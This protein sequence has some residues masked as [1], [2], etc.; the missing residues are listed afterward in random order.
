MILETLSCLSGVGDI[1]NSPFIVPVA[2]CF[3]IA[4][5]VIASTAAATR[6]REIESQERLAAIA[7]GIMPPPTHA[8]LELT[9]VQPATSAARRYYNIRLTGIIMVG[10][11]LGVILFF[12]VLSSI[13]GER[14]VLAGAACGLVPLG[15]GI[16]FLIDANLQ[17]RALGE[18]PTH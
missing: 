15:L 8:E 11:A 6:K 17:K 12:C 4:V 9:R 10:G 16:G 7:Q 18:P 1:A 3:M 5:I 2:G 14:D 13:L